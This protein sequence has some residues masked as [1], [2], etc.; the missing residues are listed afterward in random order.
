LS[1]AWCLGDQSSQLK[2]K[3]KSLELEIE[4]DMCRLLKVDELICKS[5]NKRYKFDLT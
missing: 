3:L 4:V 1:V 2:A 5:G